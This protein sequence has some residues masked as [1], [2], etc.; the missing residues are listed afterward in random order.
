MRRLLVF[1]LVSVQFVISFGC[2]GFTMRK[3]RIDLTQ[4]KPISSSTAVRTD[5]LREF[6]RLI[7]Y[8]AVQNGLKCN[9]Y[10]ETGKYFG[11][12]SGTFN[13]MTYV[14][15]DK[16]VQVELSEFGPWGKTIRFEKL[17]RDINEML[18]QEF[19]GK[20]FI[21]HKEN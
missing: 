1:L 8:V 14:K 6:F 16:L 4:N 3:I 5:D 21:L 11:C 2:D 15:G 7:Q 12:G 9:G 20:N 10:N 19:P 18:A 13:L 17:E